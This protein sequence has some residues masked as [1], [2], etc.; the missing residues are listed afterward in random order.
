MKIA[1]AYEVLSGTQF[2]CFT[3]TKVQM[4]TPEERSDPMKREAYDALRSG[5]R[6]KGGG[7]DSSSSGGRASPPPE[8][9]NV[10]YHVRITLEHIYTGGN[11]EVS[12]L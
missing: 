8:H 12:L 3:A 5:Q 11:A 2:T 10:K 7:G 6:D 1:A 4:L 9:E